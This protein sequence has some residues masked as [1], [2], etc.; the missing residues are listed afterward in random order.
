[1]NEVPDTTWFAD[2]ERITIVSGLVV[3][4]LAFLREWVYTAGAF[5]RMQDDRDYHKARGDRYDQLLER[6]RDLT[7]RTFEVAE[8]VVKRQAGA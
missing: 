6:E 7:R 2:P 1:M 3:V 4:V 8:T 5:K